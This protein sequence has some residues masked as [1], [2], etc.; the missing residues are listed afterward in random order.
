MVLSRCY[1]EHF[2][3]NRMLRP[4]AP[5]SAQSGTT[6]L[7]HVVAMGSLPGLRCPTCAAQGKEVWVI[8]GRRCGYC[9]TPVG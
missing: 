2:D 7:D 9:G 3:S 1:R 8:P 6:P 5:I 4:D